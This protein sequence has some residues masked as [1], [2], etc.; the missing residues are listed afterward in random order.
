MI[1]IAPLSSFSQ[2]RTEPNVIYGMF[3]G[4]ALL[5]DVHYPKNSNGAGVI[6]VPGSAWSAPLSFDA[7]PL[8][9]T[10]LEPSMGGPALLERGYTLFVVNHRAAPRFPYPA[11]V[12]DVLRAVRFVRHHADQFRIDPNRIGALGGS[13]GGY[14][15]S[16]LG[17]LDGDSHTSQ[18]GPIE[19][20]SSKVQAVVALFPAT[21]LIE[22]A[23]EKGGA[24]ALMSLFVGSYYGWGQPPEFQPH[25]ARRYADASPST[26]VSPDDP[27]FLLIHGDADKIVPFSQSELFLA[28]LKQAGVDAT[29]LRMS[30]GGHGADVS[31]GKGSPDHISELVGW[32]DSHLVPGE[33]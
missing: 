32:L 12:E 33:D 6:V 5:L 8:K 24:N 16:M 27:P 21:D 18:F 25:E 19:S 1:L 22:F 4:L 26:Y 11:A 20:T 7:A 29:L 15:V 17:T 9:S 3:S 2:S 31:A 23:N 13:S 30:G 10:G 28:R 14:L